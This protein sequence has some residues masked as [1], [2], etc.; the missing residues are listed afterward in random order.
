MSY[1]VSGDS[2]TDNID[3]DYRQLEIGLPIDIIFLLISL[4]VF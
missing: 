4:R 1:M 3:V 2:M